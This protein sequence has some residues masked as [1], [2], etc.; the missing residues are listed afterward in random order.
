MRLLPIADINP[1]DA[2]IAESVQILRRGGVLAFPTETFYGLG[3]DATSESA[4]DRLFQVK[5]RDF[6]NPVAVIVADESAVTPLVEE[7][8]AAARVLMQAFWPGP[9]TLVFKA[10]AAVLPRLTAG[11]GKI[12]IRVSSHPVARLL[13]AGLEGPLT[14][15]SANLSGGPECSSA[16]DAAVT[17]GDALDAV[18]AGGKTEG[19]RGSTILDVT[20]TPPVV[21]REGVISQNRILAALG[22]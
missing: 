13:A 3:A 17:F 4:V 16:R 1:G 7:I 18:V 20:V 12:G 14:A 6:S 21:L 22:L 5:G 10:S 2:A 9:L 19:G 15:T 8:P 11:T